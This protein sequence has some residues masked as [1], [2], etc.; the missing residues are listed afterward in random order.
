MARSDTG[1]C[2]DD[3]SFMGTKDAMEPRG[4]LLDFQE[5][6][7]RPGYRGNCDEFLVSSHISLL[8]DSMELECYSF[9]SP[10]VFAIITNICK[11][12]CSSRNHGQLFCAYRCDC[13]NF[14]FGLFQ[15]WLMF[16]LSN[17]QF[18]KKS[19]TNLLASTDI[20]NPTLHSCWLLK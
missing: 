8:E 12:G 2:E 16:Q 15:I 17:P 6:K 13:G 3:L 10:P 5:L 4:P 11:D 18:T 9:F 19:Y 14:K 7:R 1:I 20:L